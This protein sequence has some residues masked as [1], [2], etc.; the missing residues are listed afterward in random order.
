MFP[1]YGI[2]GEQS[3][4]C[5]VTVNIESPLKQYRKTQTKQ[6]LYTCIYQDNQQLECVSAHQQYQLNETW[7]H[8]LKVLMTYLKLN[9][10]CLVLLFLYYCT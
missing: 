8:N 2:T 7:K 6:D 1:N 9:C 5:T 4:L 10:L 3:Y